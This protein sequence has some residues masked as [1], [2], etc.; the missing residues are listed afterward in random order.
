MNE[1]D[2]VQIRVP[3]STA[4]LGPGFDS[5]G[6][7]LNLYLSL[8]VERSE[9]W[10]II[11]E[12]ED[13]NIFPTDESNYI[14]Q[15]ALQT[16][17]LFQKS[18]PS[19]KVRMASEIPLARG[20]GSSAA[21][22]IAGIELANAMGKLGLTEDEKFR[23]ATEIEGHP[24]NVGASLF[25]GLVIGSQMDDEVVAIVEHAIELEMIAVIPK[26]ELLTK[27][28]RNVLPAQ[29][30]YSEAVRAGAIG[31]VLVAALLKKDFAL[32]GKMM[33]RDLYHQPYRRKLVPHLS[34]IEEI[35]LASGAFGVA[36]SGAGPTVICFSE[37]GKSEKLLDVFQKWDSN[38]NYRRLKIDQE[39]SR[40]KVQKCV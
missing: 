26:I 23:L 22:I 27:D 20:L 19:C 28:S 11:M 32:A 10:E 6:V 8:E 35:A 17:E 37:K 12:S 3:G 13:L 25:G 1:Y 21:A 36:L 39:G 2:M 7:A 24:D 31:N 38:M 16:A 5:L 29:L 40:V 9:S 18:L 34:E 14:I 30:S 4:N 33:Q 15:I